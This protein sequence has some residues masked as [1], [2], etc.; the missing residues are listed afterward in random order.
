MAAESDRAVHPD[1]SRHFAEPSFHDA[2]KTP[3][4][5]TKTKLEQRKKKPRR[6]ETKRRLSNA[7]KPLRKLSKP[8]YLQSTMISSLN[9]FPKRRISS[10]FL[11]SCISTSI[12]VQLSGSVT[13]NNSLSS[14]GS[15]ALGCPFLQHL[16]TRES[17]VGLLPDKMDKKEYKCLFTEIATK[18]VVD[19]VST[20]FTLSI[21][22]E[23]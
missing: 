16:S 23:L 12:P 3:A 21:D 22:C 6:G 1:F 17:F 7:I 10:G 2:T 11:F 4:R 8:I 20:D 5:G 15:L 14:A 19:A 13:C 18:S 9:L